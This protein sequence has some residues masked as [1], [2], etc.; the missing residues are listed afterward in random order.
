MSLMFLVLAQLL[1]MMASQSGSQSTT[2]LGTLQDLAKENL[3]GFKELALDESWTLKL[4]RHFSEV[5][6]KYI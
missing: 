3:E 5:S 1:Q 4:S 2:S 6:T